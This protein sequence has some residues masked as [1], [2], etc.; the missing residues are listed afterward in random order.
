M[1]VQDISTDEEL[2]DAL[3]GDADTTSDN[4][5]DMMLTVKSREHATMAVANLYLRMQIIFERV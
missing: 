1:G 3:Y 2:M 4:M 5:A